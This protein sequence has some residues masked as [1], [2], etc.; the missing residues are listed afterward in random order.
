MAD[1][2]EAIFEYLQIQLASVTGIKFVERNARELLIGQLSEYNGLFLLDLGDT[3]DDTDH[4]QLDGVNMW[5][6]N[7]A[8]V[9]AFKGSTEA[10]AP[11]EAAAQMR[12]VR[13]KLMA[14]IYDGQICFSFEEKG[15][16]HLSF[17]KGAAKTVVQST[18]CAFK[19]IEDTTFPT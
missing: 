19:Y 7:V 6:L 11:K 18:L 5:T 9:L 4:P 8:M 10:L 3:P 15:K 12:A 16:S 13:K 1:E 14:C 17:P 2:R